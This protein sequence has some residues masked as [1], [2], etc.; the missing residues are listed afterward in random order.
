MLNQTYFYWK[1]ATMKYIL[2]LVC[3][4]VSV[5]G[6]ES[7][8]PQL[9][10]QTE[11]TDKCKKNQQ[12]QQNLRLQNDF[13]SSHRFFFWKYKN[14][15]VKHTRWQLF[16]R[17]LLRYFDPHPSSA[18]GSLKS[19]SYETPWTWQNN[20]ISFVIAAVAANSSKWASLL[21]GSI[22]HRLSD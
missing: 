6:E 17:N 5:F 3:F 10:N 2:P 12:F 15:I 22:Q 8:S 7:F 16:M 21:L 20:R 11:R 13:F 1:R 14:R 9:K 19:P 4:A 18:A